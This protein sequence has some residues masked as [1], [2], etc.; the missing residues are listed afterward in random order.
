MEPDTLTESQEAMVRV[1][2]GETESERLYPD[3]KTTMYGLP[4][5][6]VFMVEASP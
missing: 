4:D 3:Q 2:H 5:R 6:S 1:V